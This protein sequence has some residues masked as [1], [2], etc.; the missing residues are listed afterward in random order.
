MSKVDGGSMT[1]SVSSSSSVVV[2]VFVGAD[3]VAE[4]VNAVRVRRTGIEGTLEVG[5]EGSGFGWVW[6]EVRWWSARQKEGA[7]EWAPHSSAACPRLINE[8]RRV[9]LED[10]VNLGVRIRGSREDSGGDGWCRSDDRR[11]VVADRGAGVR[12]GV[13]DG[14]VEGDVVAV[15][16]REFGLVGG[17]SSKFEVL[18]LGAVASRSFRLGRRGR[19]SRSKPTSRFIE[20]ARHRVQS[21]E[22]GVVSRAVVVYLIGSGP[23]DASVEASL[24]SGRQGT[25]GGVD[26]AAHVV[27]S[28]AAASRDPIQGQR[29]E[30]WGSRHSRTQVEADERAPEPVGSR[31]AVAKRSSRLDDRE[32]SPLARRPQASTA[33]GQ[34]RRWERRQPS[35]PTASATPKR[36]D[37]YARCRPS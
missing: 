34:P 11:A 6:R 1:T 35:R 14:A 29:V 27:E 7:E 13:A 12:V 4:Q 5:D 31:R 26:R 19:R 21:V 23:D 22:R 32:R 17:G 18:A 30:V 10:D 20:A 16:Q 24:R 8:G 37:T 2:V 25:L 15:A 28:R 3:R 9:G 33:R 36:I